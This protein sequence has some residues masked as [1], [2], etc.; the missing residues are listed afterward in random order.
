MNTPNDNPTPMSVIEFKGLTK[1]FAQ[2]NGEKQSIFESTSFSIPLDT[3]M[4]A[5][6]GRSGSG[7]STLLKIISGLD[8]DYNGDYFFEGNS[9]P[10]SRNAMADFRR[11]AIGIV[12]Q[13]YILLPDR[14][15]LSNV[16]IGEK[17]TKQNKARAL[18]LIEAVGLKGFGKKNPTTLSG[19]E[20][21]RVA[22]ARA[23]FSKPML[24]LADEPTGSL[25][26][27]S[28]RNILELFKKLSEEGCTI[29]IATHS[30]TVAKACDARLTI[31]SKS[32]QFEQNG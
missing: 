21:Q 28:E 29:I 30:E 24:L 9:L 13:D 2:R 16:L 19:G 3:K 7:K 11:T 17:R 6:L 25:D 12:T 14:N 15:V 27:D 23:L 1:A 18:S 5:L 22:I 20:A 8:V 10:R 31:A 4:C 26:E 32:A